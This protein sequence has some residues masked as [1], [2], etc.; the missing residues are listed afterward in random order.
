[1]VHPPKV[2]G[3]IGLSFSSLEVYTLC[4]KENRNSCVKIVATNL[5]NGWGVA[6]GVGNGTQ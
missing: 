6:R 5:L 3:E 2:F 4:Q 1:M